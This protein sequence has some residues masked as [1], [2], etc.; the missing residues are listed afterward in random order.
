MNAGKMMWNEMVKPNC[1]RDRRSAVGSIRAIL[2]A[3][4]SIH[5]GVEGLSPKSHK[6][7]HMLL[8]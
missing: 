8:T 4:M 2:S 5:P 3:R 1:I 7:V 6:A